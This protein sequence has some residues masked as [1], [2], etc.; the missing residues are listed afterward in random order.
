MLI[1]IGATSRLRDVFVF[2]PFRLWPSVLLP[3]HFLFEYLL[4]VCVFCEIALI[5]VERN[6]CALYVF[7]IKMGHKPLDYIQTN[8]QYPFPVGGNDAA[9][10]AFENCR[11]RCA[12]WFRLLFHCSR[13]AAIKNCVFV[14]EFFSKEHS[15]AYPFQFWNLY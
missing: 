12:V 11:E 13:K 3:N 6:S 9:N 14:S 4:F 5:G 8:L 1:F 15:S 2:V 7:E 10:R